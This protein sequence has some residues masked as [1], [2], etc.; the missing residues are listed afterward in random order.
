MEQTMVYVRPEIDSP[1]RLKACDHSNEDQRKLS[2]EPA[3][4]SARLRYI[5]AVHNMDNPPRYHDSTSPMSGRRIS[6][7]SDTLQGSSPGMEF[8]EGDNGMTGK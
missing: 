7:E 2:G 4:S 6:T 3:A 1:P 5:E 8:L